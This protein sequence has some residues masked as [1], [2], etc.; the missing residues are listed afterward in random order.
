MIIPHYGEAEPT[1][2]VVCQLL[3][4]R[5][6]EG[7]QIIVADDASPVTVPDGAGYQVVRRKRNGG[8]GSAC[9]SG[10]VVATGEQLIFLNSDVDMSDTFIAELLVAAAPWQPAVTAPQVREGAGRNHVPRYFPRVRHF[11]VEWLLP[12]ARFERRMWWQAAIGHDIPALE[13]PEP[14]VTDWVTGR[15]GR[16]S[17]RPR[18]GDGPPG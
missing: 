5:G 12:L 9:N 16:R 1:M 15:S 17:L 6:V 11:V 4:Q 3:A 14:S 10:A 2:A 7:L 13:S 18:S 8:Y